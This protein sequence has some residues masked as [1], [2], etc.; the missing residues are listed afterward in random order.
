MIKLSNFKREAN[1]CEPEPI[2]M[3]PT[4]FWILNI[5]YVKIM[6]KSIQLLDSRITFVYML[7]KYYKHLI[8]YNEHKL[9]VKF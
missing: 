2:C 5:S 8:N 3:G 4:K 1:I 6:Y 7:M 9:K